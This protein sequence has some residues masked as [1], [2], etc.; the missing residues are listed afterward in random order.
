MTEYPKWV[1][2]HPDHKVIKDA[3][4]ELRHSSGFEFFRQRPSSEVKVLVH[5]TDDERITAMPPISGDERRILIDGAAIVGTLDELVDRLVRVS[6]QCPGVF[7]PALDEL[8]V[9]LQ[10]IGS[11]EAYE[12][13]IRSRIRNLDAL[14]REWSDKAGALAEINRKFDLMKGAIDA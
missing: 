8:A 2:P 6:K 14:R 10:E 13:L 12:K 7:G 11:L 3:S 4:G 1:A 9:K 5:D